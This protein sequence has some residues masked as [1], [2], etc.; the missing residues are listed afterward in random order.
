MQET[1]HLSPGDFFGETGLLAGIGEMATLRAMTDIVVYEVD[2]ESFAPLLLERPELAE[3]IAAILSARMPTIGKG[4]EPRQQSAHSKFALL[5]SIQE[6]FR[7][8]RLNT[9]HHL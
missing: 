1:P 9:R 5:R 2:Q 4:G 3:N 7:L 6:V 8:K